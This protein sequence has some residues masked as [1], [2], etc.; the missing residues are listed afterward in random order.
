M[1]ADKDISRKLSEI[2]VE[3][4]RLDNNLKNVTAQNKLLDKSMKFNADPFFTLQK[5]SENLARAISEITEKLNHLKDKQKIVEEQ[6]QNG[7]ITQNE[8]D[9]LTKQILMAEN[10]L[11]TFTNELAETNNAIKN[12]KVEELTGKFKNIGTAVTSVGRA[13]ATFSAGAAG[14]LAVGAKTTK[15]AIEQGAAID[16]LAQ[17][18]QVSALTVQRWQYVAMQCGIEA[19]GLTK[20]YVKA[21][22]AM[23]DLDSGKINEQSKAIADLGINIKDFS[24]SEEAFEGILAALASME[25]GTRQ[26]TLANEIFG[27][28]LANT[29][30]PLLNAGED[31]LKMF[32]DQFAAL[33]PLTD[34]Q[35]TK[36]AALDDQMYKNKETLKNTAL[37]I[38]TSLT[39]VVQTLL[40]IVEEKVV[41]KMKS[42]A[43]F[44]QNMSDRSKTFAVGI[45]FVI[46]VLAPLLMIG[47]KLIGG[48]GSIISLIPK[49]SGMLT[50][51]SAH[52]IIAII[53]IIAV[54]IGM[55]YMKNEQFRKSV[56]NMLQMFSKLA[57][58]IMNIV[59]SSLSSIFQL[60]GGL[61]NV[62]SGPFALTLDMITSLLR[63]IVET[64]A[65]LI[66]GIEKFIN[67]VKQV[68]SFGIWKPD[69]KNGNT[70]NI[71]SLGKISK[72]EAPKFD[73]DSIYGDIEV[74]D[75]NA[76]ATNY[77]SSAITDNYNIQNDIVINAADM[78]EKELEEAISKA[79]NKQMLSKYLAFR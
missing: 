34:E 31:N 70:L 9:A 1:S 37:Q 4:K 22:A 23:L 74:P 55:L 57:M 67:K 52:P 71:N 59:M 20:A 11:S 14:L 66:N 63:P 2:N 12:F 3:V 29:L 44:F 76:S 42:V 26:V 25:N 60:V 10:Q 21:R 46:A 79:F 54:L 53:G 47:G 45:L 62:L 40:D 38:G 16:D 13:F 41:P 58:P 35:V 43:E 24:N 78:N 8:Y 50:M 30:L 49:L 36:L 6:F 56:N 33:N 18:Y 19:E 5:K 72:Y 69:K 39:P 28:K 32:T 15:S 73:F 48:I 64:I 65:W 61:L 7:K 77:N 27:D 17:R 68:L 51:L 75:F